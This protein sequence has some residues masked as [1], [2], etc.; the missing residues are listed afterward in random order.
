[1]PDSR[2]TELIRI[3]AP[4]FV[5]EVVI[6]HWGLSAPHRTSTGRSASTSWRCTG[7]AAG[8]AGSC[9]PRRTAYC[10]MIRFRLGSR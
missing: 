5:A 8:W 3:E 6:D 1:M 7:I 4:H 9:V 2:A 10:E